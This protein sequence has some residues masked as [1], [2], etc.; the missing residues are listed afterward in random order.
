VPDQDVILRLLKARAS[1]VLTSSSSRGT[2]AQ[3]FHDGDLHAVGIPNRGEFHTD[4]PAPMTIADLAGS[5]AGCFQIGD[6][7][8]AVDLPAGGTAT[9]APVATTMLRVLSSLVLPSLSV[10]VTVSRAVT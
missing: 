10:T 7:L 3:H 9:L 8:L 1:S 6:N 5:L 4:G 2:G